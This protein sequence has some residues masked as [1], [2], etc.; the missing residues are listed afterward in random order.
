MCD[1]SVPRRCTLTNAKAVILLMTSLL[2]CV[3]VHY[4]W[5]FER[6]NASLTVGGPRETHCTFTKNDLRQSVFFQEKVWPA[7]DAAVGKLLPVGSL[8]G[9]CVAMGVCLARG[10]HRGTAA[11]R[12]WRQRYTL[13]PH[14]VE[15]LVWMCFVVCVMTVCLTV[16]LDVY[17]AVA[18]SAAIYLDTIDAHALDSL[19]EML[20]KQASYCCFSLKIFFYIASSSRFRRE[21]R[22]VFHLGAN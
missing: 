10:R 4:F 14:G 19:I 16:P 21:L 22:S 20:C 3:N 12:Q 7:L 2:T 8:V 1:G 15:Q 13:E 18:D 6:V 9:C 11:Y 17:Q 5:S